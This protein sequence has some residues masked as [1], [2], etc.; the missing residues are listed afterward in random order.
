[1]PVYPGLSWATNDLFIPSELS[2]FPLS[3][4]FLHVTNRIL[5][6]RRCTFFTG[7]KPLL[8]PSHQGQNTE[9]NSS[10]LK[11]LNILTPTKV[12][13][14]P[15]SYFLLSTTGLRGRNT[16]P[17]LCQLCNGNHHH[18]HHHHHHRFYFRQQGPYRNIHTEYTTIK[19][20]KS[21]KSKTK[22]QEL[23]IH[24]KTKLWHINIQ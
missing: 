12:S 9:W 10:V 23:K 1:M 17:P 3:F 19:S 7:L 15:G 24:L 5:G 20:E 18:H 2:S 13:Y 8:W 21:Y 4:L 6:D 14:H 16:A 11:K 22:R